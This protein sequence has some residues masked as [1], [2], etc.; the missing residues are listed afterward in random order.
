MLDLYTLIET[1]TRAQKIAERAAPEGA[2]WNLMAW[3]ETQIQQSKRALLESS[4]VE[5]GE[6]SHDEA[7]S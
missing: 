7:G 5:G 4:S 6:D 2:F 1:K 3:L